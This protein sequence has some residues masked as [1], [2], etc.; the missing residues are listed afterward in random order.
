MPI[1]HFWSYDK[2]EILDVF[3]LLWIIPSFYSVTGVCVAYG[4]FLNTGW[5]PL[6]HVV[7]RFFK[8]LA[9]I[10][11]KIYHWSCIFV[12]NFTDQKWKPP[13][14]VIHRSRNWTLSLCQSPESLDWG[15]RIA[16]QS[17]PACITEEGSV[18]THMQSINTRF[19]C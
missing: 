1:G 2:D 10:V 3:S 6:M 15:R 14:Y 7:F 4:W 11:W 18:W 13:C 9:S 17:R 8:M 19:N 16:V 5:I 12:Y